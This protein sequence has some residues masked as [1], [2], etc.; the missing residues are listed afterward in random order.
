MERTPDTSKKHLEAAMDIERYQSMKQPLSPRDWIVS[1]ALTGILHALVVVTAALPPGNYFFPFIDE[2]L[3]QRD[4]A[5][6]TGGEVEFAETGEDSLSPSPATVARVAPSGDADPYRGAARRQL[7][8]GR[9]D[10]ATIAG[11]DAAPALLTVKAGF[12]SLTQAEPTPRLLP[13]S[14]SASTIP[15]KPD[16][17]LLQ[18]VADDAETVLLGNV[19]Q[20]AVPLQGGAAALLAGEEDFLRRLR[21]DIEDGRLDMGFAEFIL[22][23][24]Y[25]H[26]VHSLLPLGQQPA[27]TLDQAVARYN[28]RLAMVAEGMPRQLDAYWLVMLLQRYSDNKFYPG[29]GSG[30]LL[31]GL[32]HQ[33]NDCEGG[34]KEVLA[35]L[36]SL[37]PDL[38]LG[39]NRGMLQTTTGEFIGH[40][41]GYIGPGPPA[42]KILDNSQGLIIETTRIGP[43]SVVPYQSGEIFPLEDFVVRYYPQLVVGT[44][45]EGLLGSTA[46][47][48]TGAPGGGRIVG[49]SDHPL[50]MS[51]G[52][53]SALLADQ[54]YDL[55]AIR[56]QRIANEFQQSKVPSCNPRIDP[57][58][59]DRANLFSNFVTIDRKLRKPLIDHYLADLIYW[60]NE[61]M[62]Q[63][64]QPH[65][66][67]TYNDLVGS[68]GAAD[69]T[70]SGHLQVDGENTVPALT[71]KS[72]GLFLRQLA[73]VEKDE[74]APYYGSGQRDCQTRTVLDETLLGFLFRSPQGPGLFFL[75]EP[76]QPLRWAEVIDDIRNHCLAVSRQD[77]SRAMVATLE[78]EASAG[79][80]SFRR[81]LY[82]QVRGR[83]LGPQEK[84]DA[85]RYQRAMEQLLAGFGEGDLTILA[86]R[87]SAE[88]SAAEPSV[89]ETITRR[90]QSGLNGGLLDDGVDFL[91]ADRFA[92]LLGAYGER[93]DLRL[94]V[95]RAQELAMAAADIMGGTQGATLLAAWREKAVSAE[96]RLAA[97]MHLARLA[98]ESRAAISRLAARDLEARPDF[99]ASTLLA[100]LNHGLSLED[101]R[102]VLDS[103]SSRL[104]GGLPSLA[105]SPPATADHAHLFVDMV[106]LIKALVAVPEKRVATAL[107]QGLEEGLVADF[108]ARSP[109][110]VD[111]ADYGLIFNKL[112]VLSILRQRVAEIAE[113]PLVDGWWQAFLS[114][115]ADQPVGKLMLMPVIHVAGQDRTAE[116][117][118][119]V[120]AA[121]GGSLDRLRV[122]GGQRGA[123]LDEAKQLLGIGNVVARL[124]PLLESTRHAAL[125]ERFAGK[126]APAAWYVERLHRRLAPIL[127]AYGP[128]A[129]GGYNVADPLLQFYRDDKVRE[130]F[131]L[132]AYFQ[133]GGVELRFRRSQDLASIKD[134]GALKIIE[135]E[136]RITRQD[137]S[138]LTLALNPGNSPE[139][140]RRAWEE[141]LAVVGK[142]QGLEPLD[143]NLRRYLFAPHYPYLI[144]ND[145]GFFFSPETVADL[146][147]ADR[148]GGRNDLLLSSYLHFRHLPERLPDWLRRA[149]MARS[150]WE[151]QTL[152]KFEQQ[153]FL[154]MILE[155][156]SDSREL[157]E[158]LFRAK[159]D[160][161]KPFGEDIFPGTLLLLRLGYLEITA[162]GDIVRTPKYSGG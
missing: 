94:S 98:G 52:G 97:A 99:R 4:L 103:R 68:L 76:T 150:E 44:P 24:E 59:I 19:F 78:S 144:E 36:R 40:M 132:L 151:L 69:D 116:A 60:E 53:S 127:Q 83:G 154:P 56:T 23:A 41:Q 161:R 88:S 92:D 1:L 125:A 126:G 28:E 106:E 96:L 47:G 66:L 138:L 130:S 110:G 31:D 89:A 131:A 57:G 120:I 61:I 146:H 95:G 26:L 33:Q 11:L 101:A 20:D 117:I 93:R 22:A 13:P 30:M 143:N 17:S 15:A 12:R 84:D 107:Q 32:F 112:V 135:G 115:A 67:P 104:L 25:Y 77:G 157:P 123:S 51:Y 134:P 137:M 70:F 50:K 128:A 149:A 35:Y 10:S 136:R 141:T 54:L 16:K 155:C 75:P 153:T 152:K 142:H 108:S 85:P 100:L 114:F 46:D 62:P 81:E 2:E 34:T 45:L 118:G 9:G 87:Q 58:K 129:V 79:G 80:S 133:E 7:E 71:L 86:S 8:H 42:T 102:L 43:D 105:A 37:Y 113:Q 148:W 160:I 65:F 147:N 140:M 6:G 124:L 122:P 159:W 38:P 29:N 64:R 162:A 49:T 74:D 119:L 72:H 48:F 18:E 63:W 109:A 111:G 121:Q 21:S 158:G 91:G 139:A 39:T 3:H 5:T 90:G 73:A 14:L 156:D 145:S 82:L 55:D 27:F